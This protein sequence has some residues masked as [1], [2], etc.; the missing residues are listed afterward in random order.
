[1]SKN[2]LT[3]E[4][5][6]DGCRNKHPA[7]QRALVDRYS[8]LLFAICLRY[9]ANET[10]SKDVLQESFIRIFKSFKNF[11]PD[12]GSLQ[13][14]MKKITV[15]M[16]LKSLNKRDI[17]SD[18]LSVDINNKIDIEPTALQKLQA[19]D[20]MKIIQTLPEGYR[21]VFNLSVVEGYKHNEIA[22]MLNIKEVTS[23]SNLSRAK[24]L[25]RKKLIAF[26]KNES[27]VKIV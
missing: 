27:W 20:L 5:I 21:Q 13:A 26:K 7:C 18:I 25:L 3:A 19:E 1:M 16:A 4:Q 9:T 10:R 17:T 2:H 12:K 24:Q 15:N 6:I 11:D 23:R 8:N 22:E 14:W